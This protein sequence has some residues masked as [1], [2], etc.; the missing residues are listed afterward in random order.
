MA[1]FVNVTKEEMQSF[2]EPQGFKEIKIPG[3]VEMVFAKR[4]DR[5]GMS[6][7]LRVYTGINPNGQSREVGKDAIRV[8]LF[9]RDDKGQITRAG[10]GC[11]R[12]H[13]VVNW[14]K[15]LQTRLND[16]QSLLGPACGCCNR[17][18]VERKGKNGLFW[19]CSGYP[20][21]RVTQNIAA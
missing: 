13:R 11:K 6:L 20:A 12:V 1:N 4:V 7:S 18:M 10:H 9:Y 16:W 3:T 8:E 14:R 2:L 17:P 5:D 19:G 21:C 15:N